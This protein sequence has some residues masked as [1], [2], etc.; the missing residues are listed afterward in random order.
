MKKYKIYQ[1]V[2]S[3]IALAM[4][5]S[6]GTVSDMESADGKPLFDASSFQKVAVLDFGNSAPTKHSKKEKIDEHNE[7]VDIAGRLFADK[8]AAEIRKRNLF[9]EVVRGKTEG[10]ALV[11]YGDVTRYAEGNAA[12]RLFIGLGAGSSYFDAEVN[13]KSNTEGSNLAVLKVDKN[14]WVLGG[15]I[16]A[17]QTVENYMK[18]AAEKIADELTK[19]FEP[20]TAT[21]V[22]E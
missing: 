14:S 9:A 7:K 19:S 5:C 12:A 15:G 1:T 17:G 6:C 11:I 10:E 21:P 18:T 2:P 22:G 4:L 13:F 8:I 3:I 16:A 20:E